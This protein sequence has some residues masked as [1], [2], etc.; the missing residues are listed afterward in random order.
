MNKTMLFTP[1]EKATDEVGGKDINADPVRENSL[2]G[3]TVLPTELFLKIKKGGGPRSFL[4]GFILTVFF[5]TGFFI[6]HSFATNHFLRVHFIDVGYGDAILVQSSDGPVSLIDS[7]DVEYAGRVEKYLRSLAIKKIHTA[8]LT[9]PHKNHFGGFYRL[10]DRISI[11]RFYSNGD[12]AQGEEGYQEMLAVMRRQSV[13]TAV[14]RRGDEIDFA[15]NDAYLKV[16]HPPDLSSSANENSIVTWL[17][18]GQ[19][20]FLFTGDIQEPQQAQLIELFP[21]IKTADCIQIPHHGGIVSEQFVSFF[22]NV[23]VE[24]Q[25]RFFVISTGKNDYNKPFLERLR[26]VQGNILR[27]DQMGTITLESDGR[28]VRVVHE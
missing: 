27:T 16:L 1:L 13:A 28:K 6:N 4:R 12:D 7:G 24:K 14:L 25:E 5:T 26:Q 19:T 17:K 15:A 22:D 18:F 9:H 2:T 23:Q 21:E 3:F 20:S 8:I 11:D 10:A